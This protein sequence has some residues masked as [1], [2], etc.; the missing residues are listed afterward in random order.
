MDSSYLEQ[1]V[2]ELTFHLYKRA[3]HP[4]LFT[5][6]RKQRFFLG[7]YETI[8]WIFGC[9][10]LVSVFHGSHSITEVICSPDQMLPQRGLI[11]SIPFR[12]EKNISCD[13]GE[14]FRY[15]INFQVETM[16]DNLFR[17]THKD[18]A[19][20]AKKRGIFVPFTQWAKDKLVPFSYLDFEAHTEDLQ[21]HAFHAFPDQNSIIK[22]QTLF[23]LK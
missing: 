9:S 18:L 20:M 19:G 16:S 21:V 13:W 5:I 7:D 23:L 6:Y 10:H 15:Q 2:S 8:I 14:N 17:A 1:S 3:L 12:G 22:T 11:K 4:E